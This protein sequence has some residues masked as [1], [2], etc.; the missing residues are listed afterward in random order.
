MELNTLIKM[1]CVRNGIT[2]RQL[3]QELGFSN[4][5]LA[6]LKFPVANMKRAEAICKRLN[7]PLYKL[8]GGEPE[9]SRGKDAEQQT[10]TVLD[11]SVPVTDDPD[12]EADIRM[13]L[14]L[15]DIGRAE[16]RGELRQMLRL[17]KYNDSLS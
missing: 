9:D 13:L 15:N 10:E 3:E 12:A 11:F 14:E 4:G 16:I 5:Y 7:I 6:T 8:V 17:K 2:P 1:E